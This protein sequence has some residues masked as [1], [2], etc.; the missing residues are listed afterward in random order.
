M[1]DDIMRFTVRLTLVLAWAGCIGDDTGGQD[2]TSTLTGSSTTTA[3]TSAETT[4]SGSTTTSTST[5]STTGTTETDT[6]PTGQVDDCDP[7][8]LDSCPEGQKCTAYGVMPG[9]Y[10]NGNKC[11]PVMGDD[12]PGEACM[13]L[14]PGDVSSGIDTC[15]V[16]SICLFAESGICHEFCDMNDQCNALPGYCVQAN[17]GFLPICLLKCDPLLQD[18]PSEQGCYRDTENNGFICAGT[19]TGMSNGMDNDIC[20]YDNQCVAG[21]NCLPAVVVADCDPMST[22]CCAPFCDTTMGPG[23][24]AAGE[25]CVAA[26]ADPP[27]ELM[28]VGLC[29]VP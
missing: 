20:E 29:A 24:C 17:G 7:Q 3:T 11:V 6:E 15:A 18:C 14:T 23:P 26:L 8:D 2:G 13:I 16:G 19:D 22:G 21:F 25:E 27:P 9:D 5:T 12:Q 4:T 10:W 1:H 28:N